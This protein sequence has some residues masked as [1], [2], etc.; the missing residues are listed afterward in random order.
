M[1]NKFAIFLCHLYS[2]GDACRSTVMR[3]TLST[4]SAGWRESD[5]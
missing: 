4:H 2:A 5:G 3:M 1:A